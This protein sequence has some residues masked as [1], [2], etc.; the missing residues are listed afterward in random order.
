MAYR[1]F[2]L[3]QSFHARS[4]NLS[5][6]DALGPAWIYVGTWQASLCSSL[7]SRA[8]ACG[9]DDVRS[10]VTVGDGMAFIESKEAA[11][12]VIIVD[13]SDPEGPAGTL[14][15]ERFYK[16]VHKALKPGGIVC[17]QVGPDPS[18][19]ETPEPPQK[20]RPPRQSTAHTRCLHPQT[21]PQ[22]KCMW[23]PFLAAFF[24]SRPRAQETDLKAATSPQGE[25]MWLHL[26]L[27]KSMMDF[28]GSLFGTVGYAFTS[29]PTYPSGAPPHTPISS[30]A[31]AC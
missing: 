12:D 13:S 11:Y 18:H 23:L 5:R 25:C 28:V 6:G 8:V 21:P 10:H 14:F 26:D 29:I 30:F 22:G 31:A 27:I 2:L 19:P 15:G 20:F 9:F 17:S 7:F 4:C 3:S 24:P 16:S 1:R